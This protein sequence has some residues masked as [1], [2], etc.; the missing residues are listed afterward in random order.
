MIRTSLYRL[1]DANDVLLYVGVTRNP[2]QR[3]SGHGGKS[4]WWRQVARRVV[5]DPMPHDEATRQ[6]REAIET[7]SPKYNR[8]GVRGRAYRKPPEYTRWDD[9]LPHD[10]P[11]MHEFQMA[12]IR[13]N[14]AELERQEAETALARINAA[15]KSVSP[16]KSVATWGR[17]M[18]AGCPG[19]E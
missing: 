13:E 4:P 5:S 10:C 15:D 1:Y 12:K 19:L 17:W 2:E 3:F 8:D 6:E 14:I 9:K 11:T 16:I 18:K 7:E